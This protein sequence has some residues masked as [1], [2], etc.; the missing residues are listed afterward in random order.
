M[1]ASHMHEV[2]LWGACGYGS[3]DREAADNWFSNAHVHFQCT[4]ARVVAA[5][6][7]GAQGTGA[8]A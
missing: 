8:A 3:T 5:A 7:A 2:F 6:R 1:A 4:D